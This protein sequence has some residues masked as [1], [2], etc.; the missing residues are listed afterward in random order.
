MLTP[1][2]RAVNSDG[3]YCDIR[4]EVDG[5]RTH[6]IVYHRETSKAVFREGLAMTQKVLP[7]KSS[8]DVGN[9]SILPS[10]I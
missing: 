1:L 4:D 9:V 6:S 5:V 10:D 2:P 3:G 7:K 8:C